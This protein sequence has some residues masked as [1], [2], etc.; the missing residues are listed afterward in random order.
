MTLFGRLIFFFPLVHLILI[1]LSGYYLIADPSLVNAVILVISVYILP[2]IAFR[3][4]KL[5]WPVSY[6]ISKLDAP[7]YSP[8]WAMHRIQVLFN[9]IPVFERILYLVPGLFSVWLRLWGSKIGKNVYWAGCCDIT[10]RYLLDIGDNV[11]VGYKVAFY[12]HAVTPTKD[13]LVLCYRDIIVKNN[14]MLGALA[15]IGPGVIVH[16]KTIVKAGSIVKP[17]RYN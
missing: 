12:G 2:I 9:Y 17:E 3:A 13:G 8:W 1:L 16:E 11:I 6:G 10:D 15:K 4:H 5:I 7:S 14:S